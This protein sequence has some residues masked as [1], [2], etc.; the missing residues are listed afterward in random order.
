[1]NPAFE[2][3][4]ELTD[5]DLEF[6]GVYR[7]DKAWNMTCFRDGLKECNPRKCMAWRRVDADHG[8]CVLIGCSWRKGLGA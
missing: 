4:N 8:Y 1:M 3:A 6:Q 7:N 2:K 5:Q